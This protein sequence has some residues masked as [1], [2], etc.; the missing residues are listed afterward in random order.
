VGEKKLE[1]IILTNDQSTS[2]AITRFTIGGTNAGDF[3]ETNNC[4]KNVQGGEDCTITVKF[5]PAASGTRSGTL[6][7]TDGAG[8]QTVKLNGTGK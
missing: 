5:D 7:I 6:T 2:L 3:T 1:T 4:G 8:T